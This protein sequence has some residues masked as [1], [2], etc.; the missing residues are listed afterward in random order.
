MNHV[1][2][3]KR[4]LYLNDLVPYL[5]VFFV[6][7]WSCSS[8]LVLCGLTD[9]Y[10][11]KKLSNCFGRLTFLK[12]CLRFEIWEFTIWSSLKIFSKLNSGLKWARSCQKVVRRKDFFW[13]SKIFSLFLIWGGIPG[14]CTIT[15]ILYE[16]SNA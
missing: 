9:T 7:M 1:S 10:F 16:W 4:P 6:G 2:H 3:L 8:F 12:K 5:T 15:N 11:W 13:S 14:S